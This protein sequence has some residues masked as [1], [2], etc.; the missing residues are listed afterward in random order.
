VGE[1]LAALLA[2]AGD[3]EE[4]VV[5]TQSQPIAT[6]M[7]VTNRFTSKNWPITA[8]KAKATT[9]DNSAI[10]SGTS[11]PTRV[12][13]TKAG[14]SAPPATRTESRPAGGL[15]QDPLEVTTDRELTG[16][17]HRE[18]SS[19]VGALDPGGQLAGYPQDRAKQSPCDCDRHARPRGPPS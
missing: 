10:V 14:S 7:L 8:T 6:S 9:I 1:A 16:D 12:P 15:P 17:V 19:P 13:K 11:V 5:D 2:Q 4:R 18:A 3:D